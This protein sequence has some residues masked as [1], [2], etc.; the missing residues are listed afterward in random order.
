M[1]EDKYPPT[2]G[3]RRFVKGVVGSAALTGVG[4]TT[5]AGVNLTTSPTGTGGGQTVFYGIENT[6]GPAPRGM[7]MIP[8]R[9]DNEGYLRGYYPEVKEVERRG[10]TV[11]VAQEQLGG[12]EYSAN[13]FQYCGVQGYEGIQPAY[14]GDNYFRYASGAGTYQ[15][16]Q[17]A[18][19]PGQRVNVE[20][21][22]DYETWGNGIGRA[23]I[24]KPAL[25]TWRSQDTENTIPVQVL[26][27]TLLEDM[28]ASASGAPKQWLDASTQNGFMAWLNKCTHFCCVPGFKASEQSAE[29][30]AA[31]EVYCP[32]HQSVYDPFS[33]VKRS[34]IAFPRPEEG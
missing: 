30:G 12:I 34:F 31:N 21:F 29:F 10:R 25:V 11:T 14:K 28:K 23:G 24:G 20:D 32:C 8:V 15:W 26:R 7:P 2:S 4:A 5:A 33:I 1:T 17:E 3:R 16:Q 18:V 22:S 27:S 6:D 13:W 19:S 9:I